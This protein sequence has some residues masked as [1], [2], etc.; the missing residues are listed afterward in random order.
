M[1]KS[2]VLL[3]H[4]LPQIIRDIQLMGMVAL[5]I[6]VDMLVLTAWNLTDPIK[7]ARSVGAVVKVIHWALG[8]VTV[9][10]LKITLLFTY[11]TTCEDLEIKG[12]RGQICNSLPVIKF[13]DQS[14]YCCEIWKFGCHGD[15]N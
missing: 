12:V 2:V 4:C 9:G 15:C 13:V 8:G 6:L 3:C 1:Y 11:R 7:C 14:I 5:L 10:F